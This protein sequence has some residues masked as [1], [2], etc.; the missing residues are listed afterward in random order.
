MYDIIKRKYG[1]LHTHTQF[2]YSTL[3][4]LS[5]ALITHK[6]VQNKHTT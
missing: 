4:T 1:K 5:T 6:A 3:H 2:T